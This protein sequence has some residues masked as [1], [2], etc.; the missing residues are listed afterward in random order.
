MAVSL[1][2][3]SMF[4]YG[5]TRLGSAT[6]YGCRSWYIDSVVIYIHPAIT[7]KQDTEKGSETRIQFCQSILGPGIEQPGLREGQS[8]K[9]DTTS[10]IVT[11]LVKATA[12]ITNHEDCSGLI[13]IYD[14]DYIYYA[15]QIALRRGINVIAVE[16]YIH[17]NICAYVNSQTQSRLRSRQL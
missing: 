13:E 12:I 15:G 6:L 3:F 4:G 9:Y 8:I 11:S 16:Y 17:D 14:D 5:T 10:V 7:V 1:S 2:I